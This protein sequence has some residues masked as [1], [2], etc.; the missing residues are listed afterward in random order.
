MYWLPLKLI[1]R[2]KRSFC[3]FSDSTNDF[4]F[5]FFPSSDRWTSSSDGVSLPPG[6]LHSLRGSQ[7]LCRDLRPATSLLSLVKKNLTATPETIPLSKTLNSSLQDKT[8]DVFLHNH[9]HVL[10]FSLQHLSW[11][12][13]YWIFDVISCHG[14]IWYLIF[15][16]SEIFH[17]WLR[18][19]IQN[20][21]LNVSTVIG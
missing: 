21:E 2:V 19:M 18:S 11:T 8:S 17:I 4:C 14:R 10:W 16:H 12:K 1:Q 20:F 9:C 5:F 6:R 3:A 13:K 7:V 15:H